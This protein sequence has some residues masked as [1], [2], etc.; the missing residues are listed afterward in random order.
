[1]KKIF[2]SFRGS[3][4]LSAVESESEKIDT[5]R[6][7]GKD[8]AGFLSRVSIFSATPGSGVVKPVQ[9]LNQSRYS[10]AGSASIFSEIS[11]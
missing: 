3:D 6:N 11:I 10:G 8:Q 5:R 2:D 7:R 1:L 9:R 4:M